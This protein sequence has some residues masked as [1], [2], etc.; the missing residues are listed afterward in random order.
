MSEGVGE[1]QLRPVRGA[2][3]GHLLDAERLA[4]G[5]DVLGVVARCEEHAVGTD[6]LGTRG[7]ASPGSCSIG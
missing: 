6:R 1:R 5:V 2:P 7:D 4:D 3:E